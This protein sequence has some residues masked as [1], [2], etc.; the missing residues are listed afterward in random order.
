[1]E[2]EQ[3]GGALGEPRKGWGGARGEPRKGWGGARGEPRT[4]LAGVG[5]GGGAAA[6]SVGEDLGQGD[7]AGFV[8]RAVRGDADGD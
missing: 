4:R 2:D 1:M 7:G 5:A 6:R 3:G 8:D